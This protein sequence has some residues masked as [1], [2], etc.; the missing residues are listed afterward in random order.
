MHLVAQ[1]VVQAGSHA[2]RKTGVNAYC[3]YHSD[4]RWAEAPPPESLP[5]GQ[6]VGRIIEVSPSGN[7]VRSYLEVTAPDDTHDM[8]II[9][10]VQSGANQLAEKGEAPPW[11]LIHGEV[12]FSFD[13]EA[14]L[15]EHWQIELRLLLG[16]ALAARPRDSGSRSDLGILSGSIFD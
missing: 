12:S 10:V 8:Q 16:Y 15:A 7:R 5:R 11:R 9:G 6:L 3:Y 4:T 13:V 1:R 2:D 14:A